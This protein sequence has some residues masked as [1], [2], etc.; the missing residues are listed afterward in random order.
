MLADLHTHTYFSDG[1]FS[2][3]ALVDLACQKNVAALAV[4]DHDTVDGCER[5]ALRSREKGIDFVPGVELSIEYD[6]PGSGHLHLLGLF[7]DY[8]K[9]ELVQALAKLKEAR[10]LRALKILSR[11]NSLGMRIT[12]DELSVAVKDGSPG[13]PHIVELMLQKGYIP[14]AMEGYTRYLAK[15][16]PAYVP[17]EKLKLQAAIQL[18]HQAGGLAILAHPVSLRYAS[19]ARM[20]EEILKFKA[21][22]LDGVEVFYPS[23]DYYFTKWLLDFVRK[24]FL[25]V[26]GGSDFH[27]LAKADIELG[28]GR[29]NLK[30]AYSVYE[31]LKETLGNKKEDA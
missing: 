8:K 31:N 24:Y 7:I 19:Y 23:H 10:K 3:E 15:G 28:T 30:V 4:T 12:T 11:L 22:G 16:K 1:T 13:R 17:K 18:I 26:S 6:L 21:M 5:A 14:N 29:G 9:T 25:A 20:G 2:P 27:G